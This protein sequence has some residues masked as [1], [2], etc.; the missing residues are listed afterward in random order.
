MNL[1]CNK[2]AFSL[3]EV[4]IVMGIFMLGILGLS[5]LI[6]QNLNAQTYNRDYLVASMLAQEGIELTRNLRDENWLSPNYGTS[7]FW[8]TNI[9]DNLGSV[10]PLVIAMKSDGSTYLK[11]NPTVNEQKLYIKDGFYDHDS[12]GTLTPYSRLITISG[13]IDPDF[14][15][16]VSKVTWGTHEYIAETKLYNWR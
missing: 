9:Y 15:D 13:S 1:F 14:L 8:Y 4:V 5:T 6:T 7:V 2:K 3:L 16:V 11:D 10:Y 12:S